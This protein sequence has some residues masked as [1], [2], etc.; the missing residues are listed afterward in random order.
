MCLSD[1]PDERLTFL[2]IFLRLSVV[3]AFKFI[4]QSGFH[5]CNTFIHVLQWQ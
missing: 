5:R 2:A 3:T 4:A 1:A